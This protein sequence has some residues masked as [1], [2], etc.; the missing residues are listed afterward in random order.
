MVLVVGATGLLG[1]EVCRKLRGAGKVVRA[2]VRSSSAPNKL[3][4]L[5]SVGVETAV[6][7]LKEPASLVRVLEGISEI[8]TTASSTFSRQEG[9]SIESVDF[10]GTCR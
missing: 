10:P 2:M 3:D 5:R 4:T 7:D 1:A 9:D 6:A 8:I